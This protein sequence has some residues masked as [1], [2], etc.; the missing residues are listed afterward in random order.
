MSTKMGRNKTS[1]K[2]LKQKNDRLVRIHG[3]IFL[4]NYYYREKLNKQTLPAYNIS[5]SKYITLGVI[6]LFVCG[7][8]ATTNRN[9]PFFF[10]SLLFL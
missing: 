4:S 3:S 8:L 5:T 6:I 1:Y 10:L 9:L 2:K 7:K